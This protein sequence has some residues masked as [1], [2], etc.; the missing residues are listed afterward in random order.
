MIH[1]SHYIMKPVFPLILLGL[2]LPV[3][4]HAQHTAVKDSVYILLPVMDSF[5]GARIE[6]VKAELLRADSTFMRNIPYGNMR[7]INGRERSYTEF[8]R[9]CG[10]KVHRQAEQGGY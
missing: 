2:T 5:T 3:L 6:H 1:L 7:K 10:R 4:S 9:V 8:G